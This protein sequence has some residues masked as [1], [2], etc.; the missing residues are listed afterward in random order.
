MDVPAPATPGEKSSGSD[1]AEDICS[2]LEQTMLRYFPQTENNTGQAKPSS[3]PL[4]PYRQEKP[5]A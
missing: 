5:P 1:M 2:L 4:V 3:V